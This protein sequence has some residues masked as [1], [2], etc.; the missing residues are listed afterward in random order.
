M[1][2]RVF[3]IQTLP[4]SAWKNG[5]GITRT[6][7]DA[8]G[9][10]VSIAT[11]D[12]SCPFSTYSGMQRQQALLSGDGLELITPTHESLQLERAGPVLS[13]SGAV[14]LTCRL[15]GGA[16][17][18]LNVMFV[19]DRFPHAGIRSVTTAFLPDAIQDT[20]IVPVR[21]SWRVTCINNVV[22]HVTTG[23]IMRGRIQYIAPIADHDTL[24]YV[25]SS[26]M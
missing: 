25:A 1:T 18:V 11:I 19:P 24:C 5:Q 2:P 20:I 12:R 13:F 9:W 14:P 15:K 3:S 23:N 6:L 26:C 17:T 10:R 7:T 8:P 21:G 22:R 16:V 4:V